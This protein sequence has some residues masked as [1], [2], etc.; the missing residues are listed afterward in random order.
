VGFILVIGGRGM[1][2]SF[3]MGR[4]RLDSGKGGRGRLGVVKKGG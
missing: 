1:G 3:V 2:V 4:G